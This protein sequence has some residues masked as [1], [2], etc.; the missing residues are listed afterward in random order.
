[1]LHARRIAVVTPPRF[2]RTAAQRFHGQRRSKMNPRGRY[3]I[4]L[5]PIHSGGQ[6]NDVRRHKGLLVCRHEERKGRERARRRSALRGYRVNAPWMNDESWGRPYPPFASA[7]APLPSLLPHTFVTPC[8]FESDF[9][10]VSRALRGIAIRIVVG[11]DPYYILT[12]TT[13]PPYLNVSQAVMRLMRGNENRC[14]NESSP[15]KAT[16]SGS[17]SR[18]SSIFMA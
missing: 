17:T 6:E 15:S 5:I 10:S 4:R 11:L 3:Y 13:I 1:M 9:K 12:R 16:L 2:R 7:C 14:A 18:E 8:E